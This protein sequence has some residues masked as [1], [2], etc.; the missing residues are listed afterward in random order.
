MN[1]ALKCNP[2]TVFAVMFHLISRMFC[3]VSNI[4]KAILLPLLILLFWVRW[5]VS[6]YFSIIYFYYFFLLKKIALS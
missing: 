3:S 5:R 6:F 4:N 1:N 2:L